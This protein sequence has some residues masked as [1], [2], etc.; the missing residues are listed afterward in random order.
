MSQTQN[1]IAQARIAEDQARSLTDQILD[2][3]VPASEKAQVR[4]QRSALYAQAAGLRDAAIDGTRFLDI[5]NDTSDTVFLGGPP[6]ACAYIGRMHP[7]SIDPTSAWSR[8]ALHLPGG[9]T[10]HWIAYSDGVHQHSDLFQPGARVMVT[11]HHLGGGDV[12]L[13]GIRTATD[14]EWQD[15]IDGT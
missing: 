14:T 1:L 6:A 13:T 5:L 2:G 15:A 9:T 10:V 7:S 8:G 11:G 4:E 3:K 12:Y